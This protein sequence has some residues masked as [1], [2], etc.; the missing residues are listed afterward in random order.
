MAKSRQLYKAPIKR[1]YVAKLE[2]NEGIRTF[3]IEST[4][5]KKDGLF[6][7]GLFKKLISI[8][9]GTYLPTE[10]EAISYCRRSANGIIDNIDEAT[11]IYADYGKVRKDRVVSEEEF[12]QLKKTAH[13]KRR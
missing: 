13:K 3:D 1:S 7:E 5:L 2:I 6:Y 4:T 12:K 9:Y 10:E 8:D 11:C